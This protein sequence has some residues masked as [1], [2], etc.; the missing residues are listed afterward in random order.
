M[1][2]FFYINLIKGVDNVVTICYYISIISEVII[3]KVQKKKETIKK[4]KNEK[5][6]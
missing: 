3:W 1:P 2:L 4:S 5:S 6:K